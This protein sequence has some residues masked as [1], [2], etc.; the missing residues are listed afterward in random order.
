M[1]VYIVGFGERGEGFT[2]VAVTDS[3]PL[4]K[5]AAREHSGGPLVWVH[6]PSAEWTSYLPNGV[7][8]YTIE[9]MEVITDAV[10]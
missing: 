6:G 10:A 9:R 4:A 5:K 1:S 2:F 3:L 8:R 7:D